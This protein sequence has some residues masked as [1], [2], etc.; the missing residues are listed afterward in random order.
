MK[1]ILSFI[2][3]KFFILHKFDITES[4]STMSTV[5]QIQQSLNQWLNYT[6]CCNKLKNKI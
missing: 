2:T 6:I 5:M 3:T 1:L 4:N